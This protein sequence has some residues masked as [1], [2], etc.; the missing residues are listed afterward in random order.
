VSELLQE[1]QNLR[2]ALRTNWPEVWGWL[3]QF[4]LQA[5]FGQEP[6]GY[7]QE[8]YAFWKKY[9]SCIH[10]MHINRQAGRIFMNFG[11][12][13]VVEFL[14]V[15]NATYIYDTHQYQKMVIL[16]LKQPTNPHHDFKS[17]DRIDKW[18]HTRNWP[19]KFEVS[20]R[21]YEIYPLDGGR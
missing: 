1:D 17:W 4:I 21:A 3:Q 19:R 14:E 6:S 15:G 10:D 13:G 5:F 8:R 12:V 16:D 9:A 18:S 2:Q 20:L 11:L 7:N